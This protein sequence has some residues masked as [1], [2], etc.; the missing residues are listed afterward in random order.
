LAYQIASV[1][2]VRIQLDSHGVRS[3]IVQ[4]EINFEYVPFRVDFYP[5]FA[6][7]QRVPFLIDPLLPIS[8]TGDQ[9]NRL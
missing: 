6:K 5:N 2:S 1:D 4:K 8:A 3:E 7:A 9:S